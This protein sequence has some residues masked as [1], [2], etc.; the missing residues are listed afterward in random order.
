MKEQKEETGIDWQAIYSD[1]DRRERTK[2]F[3]ETVASMEGLEKIILVR[4]SESGERL[5]LIFDPDL[6]LENLED[7]EKLD[8]I[9]LVKSNRTIVVEQLRLPTKS[10][11]QISDAF[12]ESFRNSKFGILEWPHY[13]EM[14]ESY[15]QEIKESTE[16]LRNAEK[17]VLLERLK[18]TA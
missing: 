9:G 13:F 10:I 16:G 8:Q 11:F 1:E 12:N 17:I 7:G 2:R 18:K 6:A 14:T 3:V 5:Y 15:Y 4:F